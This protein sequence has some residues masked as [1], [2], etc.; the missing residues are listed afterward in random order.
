MNYS[1]PMHSEVSQPAEGKCP[2]CGMRLLP[3]NARF[4][5]FRHMLSSPLHLAIVIAV[6]LALLALAM[7]A[8]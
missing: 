2:R 1:C 8:H 4:R 6:A 3:E 7:M 5:V